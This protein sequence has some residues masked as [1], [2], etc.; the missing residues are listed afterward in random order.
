MG[1]SS[2]VL[3]GSKEQDLAVRADLDASL[4]KRIMI[5][6]GAMGTMIQTFK[7]TEEDYRG[8]RFADYPHPVKGNNELLV[9]SKP[10]VIS[11][12]HRNFMEAGADIIETNTF[13][14][15][16]LSQAD[17]HME[18]LV[19]EL[20][21]EAARLAKETAQTF[22]AEN[23]DRKVYI[24][25]AIGPTT[26]TLSLS[27]DV[28]NPAFRAV[29]WDDVYQS[30][31]EQIETLVEGGVDI[32]MPETVFDT[33]NLKACLF[34]IHDFQEKHDRAIPVIVSVTITDASGRTLSGQTTEAFWNSIS[35]AK[36]FCVGINCALGAEDMRPYVETLSKVSDCYVHVYPNAGLPNPLS[37]TG[38]DDTPE[39]MRE[40]LNTFAD[41]Q[42]VNLVGGCCGTT[43]DHIAAIAD[44]LRDKAPRARATPGGAMRLSGLEPFTIGDD[45]MKSF[46]M[47]G[48]RTNVTGSPR[49]AKLIKKGDY[50]TALSIARQQ[51]ENGANVI[52]I[53]FDEGM[54]DGI[55]AMTHFLK[56]VASEPDISKVPIMIDSSKWEIIEAGLQTVQGKAIVNSISLKEGEEAFIHYAK[57]IRQYGAATVVMA[58]D[59]YGQAATKDDKIRICQR[60]YKLLTEQAEFPADD[61][62]FDPNILTVGTGIEEHNTY[63][64]DFIEATREIKRLCPGAKV[65]GGVSN[66][67]FS[68][69]GNNPVREAM[70]AAF[71]YHAIQAGMDMGIVNAGMLAVYDEVPKELLELVEDVLLNRREDATE[72]L[73]DAAPNYL[74]QGKKEDNS[75][76]LAWREQHVAE[77][78]KHS[79]VKGI[80][81]YI[82]GDTEEARQQ[83]DRPLQVIEG[84]LM[85]G[86][87]VV[88]DL[89]GAGKMFLPQV[90]KS[91]RVMKKAVAYLLPYMEDEK[92]A[93]EAAS[94]KQGTFLIATV[95]GD[96]HDIGKNIVAV[97]LACNN[98][99]VVD[100]GVMVPCENI[101]AKAKEIDADII[102]L[103]GLITPSLDE[104]V[105][106]AKEMTRGDFEAPLL[107]GGATTSAAHTAVK[108]APHYEQPVVHVSDA[109]RVVNVVN[110]LLNPSLREETRSK[111]AARQ[112][113]IRQDFLAGRD[114]KPLISLEQSR[115]NAFQIDWETHTLE[116]PTFLGTKVYDDVDLKD[117]VELIDWT[118]FFSAWELRGRYP[119]ILEDEKVGE[120]ARKLFNDANNMLLEVIN[121]K[122][123]TARGVI[124][125]EPANTVGDDV[126]VYTDLSR[127]RVD[128]RF[129]T[130]RQQGQRDDGRPSFALSDFIAPKTS[131][132][133]DF[134]GG[135]A[136]TT[137]H[138]V[139]EFAKEFEAQHDDYNSIMAK[140]VGDRLAE[141][142]A[143]WMHREVRNFWGYGRIEALSN[144]D[145]I[146][147]KYRGI[148]PAAGYPACPDHTEK[149]TLFDWLD[150]EKN[151]GIELTESFAMTPASSVSGLYFCNREARYFSVGKIGKDQIEDY[152][153]RKE[154]DLATLEKW[155]APYLDY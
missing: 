152:A 85:D 30:Y 140:A 40:V 75:D 98:F 102:G 115:A 17:Y 122:I 2:L 138:G 155:L 94:K 38:Y 125:I 120:E 24:A 1:N 89:F 130:L 33:L 49:F 145:L 129:H 55:E 10:E 66:I 93:D 118:P 110:D 74:G 18:D 146:K 113:K 58:F 90:V 22:M 96:V 149:R 151:T 99:E 9:L 69:R 111:L 60:A 61:I 4:A 142:F 65:S 143:E 37:E 46:V 57:K 13:S 23:P 105:H 108:I 64:V 5:I 109:S 107:I 56:L 16:R 104:M 54:L 80:V 123:F 148:R 21:I 150:A 8:E 34:A 3:T 154:C 106:V 82:D 59:E 36:P 134:L 84:P 83:F 147:E 50:E 103:S 44:G 29:T 81:E 135:F 53:N 27:P 131:G 41:N 141:A 137:G 45:K 31:Y 32:L 97:V 88:G 117:L 101:L 124:R 14:S 7:L 116:T 26:K 52:D 39:Q 77:R 25:G 136:V 112:E 63:A 47:V 79:L 92:E 126:E 35:H 87:A 12:I 153:K 43:P 67:S 128:C 20:N 51:V 139:E 127:S 132:K 68:F 62:V 91:A 86:M 133:E 11:E 6:D 72:R 70:H 95:K 119:K 73:I 19:P 76:K 114:I 71:L 15:T 121:R 28:N 100:M 48:E 42:S 144:E 78:L